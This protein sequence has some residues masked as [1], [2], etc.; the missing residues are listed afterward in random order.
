MTESSKAWS[1]LRWFMSESRETKNLKH[2]AAIQGQYSSQ[3]R[4]VLLIR[5]R[6]PAFEQW[7]RK[8]SSMAM[9][10]LA[11]RRFGLARSRMIHGGVLATD[12][13]AKRISSLKGKRTFI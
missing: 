13:F 6:S 10:A 12:M 2:L 8:S 11:S 7:Q 1:L 5:L 3:S 4:I 9:A